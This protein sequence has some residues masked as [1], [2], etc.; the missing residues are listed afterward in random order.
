MRQCLT[1][2]K[3]AALTQQDKRC[4]ASCLHK[5]RESERY[6]VEKMHKVMH[7]HAMRDPNI[8]P[9]Y[10]GTGAQAKQEVGDKY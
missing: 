7:D 3:E 9:L 6:L 8:K 10:D 4:I 5:Y 1:S 2:F